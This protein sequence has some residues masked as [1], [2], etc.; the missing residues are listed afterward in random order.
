[1]TIDFQQVKIISKTILV[2]YIFIINTDNV[3]LYYQMLF[4]SNT[5]QKSTALHLAL[6]LAPRSL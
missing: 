2:P 6:F 5:L 1:M 3:L 4:S